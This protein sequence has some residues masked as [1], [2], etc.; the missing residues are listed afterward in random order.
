MP[1]ELWKIGVATFIGF[2]VM[3]FIGFGVKLIHIPINN[4][5]GA[6]GGVLAGVAVWLAP[7]EGGEKG[8]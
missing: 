4:I 2:A 3:G 7:K 6:C 5:L 1:A 8:K